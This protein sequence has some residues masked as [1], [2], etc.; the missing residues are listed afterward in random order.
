MPTIPAGHPRNILQPYHRPALFITATGTEVGKSTLA[1]ALAGALH[2]LGARVGVIKPI[3]SG[4]GLRRDLA[5]GQIPTDDDYDSLDAECAARAANLDPTDEK[6]L[7]FLSPIRY[8]APASP[9]VAARIENRQPNWQRLADAFDYWEENCDAL[10]IEGVGGWRVPLDQHDFS[11]ADLATILHVPILVVTHPR[12]GTINDTLLTVDSIR[13]RGLVVSGII[14]NQVPTN[15]DIVTRYNLDEIPRLSGVS[16]RATLPL[17]DDWP[18]VV[19]GP[20]LKQLTELMLPFA[21]QWW[22]AKSVDL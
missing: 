7:P 9:H 22:A 4:C 12:L 1:A 18:G 17:V 21:R 8:G 2:Q 20:A 3:A 19:S 11:V 14:I 13:Q 16:V 10:I 5:D 15:P 6:L